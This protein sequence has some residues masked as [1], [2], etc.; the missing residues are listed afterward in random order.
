MR[1]ELVYCAGLRIPNRYLLSTLAM[2]A[3][4]KLHVTNTRVEETTNRVFSEVASGEYLEVTLPELK[5][6]PDIDNI[7]ISPTV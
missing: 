4:R 1:S 7:L 5:P 6:A 3:V 2:K